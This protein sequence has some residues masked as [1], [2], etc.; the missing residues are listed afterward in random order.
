[1]YFFRFSLIL[2]GIITFSIINWNCAEEPINVDLSHLSQTADTLTLNAI[3]GFTYQVPPEIGSIKRLYVGAKG[4]LSFPFAFIKIHS[5]GSNGIGWDSLLDTAIIVDSVL[6]KL[7]SDDSLIS[8]DIDI[9]LY[10]STDSIFSELESN[11]LD[12]Q[13]FSFTQWTNLD[14]PVIS[15]AA[16]TTDTSQFFTETV[17]SWEISELLPTLIDTTDSNLV[18]TFG[19]GFSEPLDS[20][21]LNIFSREY[22]PGSQDPKIEVYYRQEMNLA[23][24]SSSVDTLMKTFYAV[25]DVSIV[26]PSEEYNPVSGE[27]AISQGQG[28]RSIIKVPFDSLSLPELSVIRS[29]KLILYQESDTTN[30]F[31]IIMHPLNEEVDTSEIIFDNDPYPELGAYSTS[32]TLVDGKFEI[33]LKSFLQSI[34]MVDTLTNVGMKL[35]PSLSSDLFE[36]ARFDLLSETNPARVEI[37]Y[38]TP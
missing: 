15:Q 8:P 6:F 28:F 7:Y 12:Y 33:S 20:Q 5:Y 23:P 32:S 37:L 17:L 14:R 18:R 11:Y 30:S 2:T 34:L 10:F 13:S 25:G 29:A 31:G 21:F 3:T 24:D 4:E 19:I 1:M 9:H 35:S 36:T 26:F 22:S 27:I 38:V 16:D